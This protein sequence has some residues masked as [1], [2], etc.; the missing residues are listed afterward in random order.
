M[1]TFDK[2]P[3]DKFESAYGFKPSEEWL[4]D[5]QKS[6]LQFEGGCSAAFVSEN[7]LIMTNHHCGR[8]ELFT[9]Q[10]KEKIY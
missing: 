5:V 8:N 2:V 9:V 10:K 3:I 1:W 7:G 6:A 4:N